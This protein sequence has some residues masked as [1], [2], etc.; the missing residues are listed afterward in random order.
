MLEKKWLTNTEAANLME[1]DR[2]TLYRKAVD[3]REGKPEDPRFPA[4]ALRFKGRQAFWH[5][6][7]LRQ[8]API[9]QQS[10]SN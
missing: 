8:G 3:I 7:V 9:D 1:M 4:N 2:T 10:I 5:I 6:D